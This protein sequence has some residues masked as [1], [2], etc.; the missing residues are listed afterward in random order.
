MTQMERRATHRLPST[1]GGARDE[2]VRPNA[3]PLSLPVL[4]I[5]SEAPGTDRQQDSP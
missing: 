3:P 4:A 1:L 5:F 2:K